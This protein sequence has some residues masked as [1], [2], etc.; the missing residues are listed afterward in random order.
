MSGKP[1]VDPAHIS[2]LA[3]IVVPLPAQFA[4]EARIDFSRGTKCLSVRLG[5]G[6]VS[7]DFEDGNLYHMTKWRDF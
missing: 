1:S 5:S 2:I 3:W 6:L 4:L 7:I